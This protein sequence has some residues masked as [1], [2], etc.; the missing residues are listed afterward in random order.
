MYKPYTSGYKYIKNDREIC[1]N[2]VHLQCW[3]YV[4]AF[5]NTYES[6]NKEI[7][8][9]YIESKMAILF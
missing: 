3:K 2:S 7:Y 6:I 9:W 1:E 5:L 4:N 8:F